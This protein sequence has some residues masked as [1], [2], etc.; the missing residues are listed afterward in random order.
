MSA[1]E[2]PA[3]AGASFARLRRVGLA[4]SLFC[5]AAAVVMIGGVIWVWANPE[6]VRLYMQ[7]TVGADAAPATPSTRGYWLGLI[8]S[9]VPAGLFVV[10]MLRLGRLFGRFRKGLILDEANAAELTRT[11]WL[12]VA[13]GAATP[14][15]RALQSVAL[16][17][18]NASGQR[19]LAVTLDPGIFGALAAGVVL[20]AFGLVLREAVRLADENQSFI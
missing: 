4:A 3:Q 13:F 14:V 15:V 2:A 20:V 10:A 11:G 9:L 8:L 17:W 18:D 6:S 5:Y 7:G 1:Y 12:L 16:T 19:Q